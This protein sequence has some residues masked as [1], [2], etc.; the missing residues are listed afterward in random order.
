ME[1]LAGSVLSQSEAFILRS[2]GLPYIPVQIRGNSLRER[3]I[4]R[5]KVVFSVL[6][7]KSCENKAKC[8]LE[9]IHFAEESENVSKV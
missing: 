8:V 4:N 2:S 3:C 9:F 6:V 5:S 1:M 7:H